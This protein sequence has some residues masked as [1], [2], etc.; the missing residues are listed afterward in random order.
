MLWISLELEYWRTL[1]DKAGYDWP[2]Y[3]KACAAHVNRLT[4]LIRD[5]QIAN[6]DL[7]LAQAMYG[8][9]VKSVQP[10]GI[11]MIRPFG[12]TMTTQE[13][14]AFKHS[15]PVE[16]KPKPRASMYWDLNVRP[17]IDI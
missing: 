16:E 14:S 6:R 4:P 8:M 13:I 5:S 1:L 11:S 2:I 17:I 10:L 15:H 3:R 9:S 12:P 7:I